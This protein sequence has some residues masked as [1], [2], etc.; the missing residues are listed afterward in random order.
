MRLLL[1]VLLM[2]VTASVARADQSVS[3][4]GF[5]VYYS[6]VNT[7]SLSPD[8]ASRLGVKQRSSHALLL[9]S[10]RREA[11]A[12]AK[13]FVAAA[14]SGTVR[15]LT[16]QRQELSWRKIDAAG[17]RDLVAEFEIQDGEHLNFDVSVL[18]E[19]ASY[20][21]SIKFRQQFYRD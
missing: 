8:I 12:D 10:P 2:M 6:A 20:P 3:G 19:G 4:E 21:L 9:L 7:T 16:G 11:P 17:Q 18:P 14:A 15:R 5:V 13:N 1:T